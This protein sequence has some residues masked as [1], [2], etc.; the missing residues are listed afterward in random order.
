MPQLGGVLPP[1]ADPATLPAFATRIEE[2]GYEQL[3][4]VED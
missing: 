4:V 3:W 1:H 2:L